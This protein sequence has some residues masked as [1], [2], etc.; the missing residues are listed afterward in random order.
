MKC[1]WCG[2]D[3]WGGP[4]RIRTHF[5]KDPARKTHFALCQSKAD[6]AL[7]FKERVVAAMEEIQDKRHMKTVHDELR[8][9]QR[10]A[11]AFLKSKDVV[12]AK[13]VQLRIADLNSES[14]LMMTKADL[15]MAWE[16]AFVAC[17]I[18]F[19]VL[20]NK[21]WKEAMQATIQFGNKLAYSGPSY[22]ASRE[23]NLD[24]LDKDLQAE[25]DVLREKQKPYKCTLVSDGRKDIAGHPLINYIENGLLGDQFRKV[26]DMS[27]IEKS[28]ENI[29]TRLA[30]VLD[31]GGVDNYAQVLTDSA[32]SCVKARHLLHSDPK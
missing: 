30:A 4:A 12:A 24:Q 17:A 20:R 27:G 14:C 10:I 25:T 13:G 1:K 7:A 29:A 31:D 21:E 26:D 6:A 8:N 3:F 16:K 9:Q 18:P 32:S 11:S 15:D 28:G 5:V 19:H 2:D 22:N 23:E